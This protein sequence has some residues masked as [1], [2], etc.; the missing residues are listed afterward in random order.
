MSSVIPSDPPST[1][2]Y[3]LCALRGPQHELHEYVPSPAGFCLDLVNG[4]PLKETE[5]R[6]ENKAGS[7]PVRSS[8]ADN[9]P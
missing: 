1:L 7:P 6:E 3:L 4:E 9:V 5:Q 2:L 8:C